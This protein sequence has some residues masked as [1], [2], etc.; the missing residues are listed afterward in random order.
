M[1]YFRSQNKRHTF[2][3]LDEFQAKSPETGAK[4][5][6]SVSISM[7]DSWPELAVKMSFT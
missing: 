2:S 6:T 3:F 1:T 7:T 4:L 5:A